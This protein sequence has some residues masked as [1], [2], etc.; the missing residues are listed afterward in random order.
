MSEP[1][2][3]ARQRRRNGR[4][5]QQQVDTAVKTQSTIKALVAKNRDAPPA[6]AGTVSRALRPAF[7][8][9]PEKPS[10]WDIQ[11]SRLLDRMSW[12][13]P[14]RAVDR[15]SALTH[16]T[17]G[18]KSIMA[19]PDRIRKFYESKPAKDVKGRALVTD[20]SH[21]AVVETML[22]QQAPPLIRMSGYAAVPE[23]GSGYGTTMLSAEVPPR[24]TGLSD[25]AGLYAKAVFNP[26][27]EFF[28]PPC[29]PDTPAVATYRYRTV[30]RGSF[31]TATVTGNGFIMVRPLWW[32]NNVSGTDAG[33]Y[34]TDGAFTGTTFARSGVGVT[35]QA[36]STLPYA[37]ASQDGVSGRLVGLG[38]RI[39]STAAPLNVNGTVFAAQVPADQSLTGWTI[40]ALTA[41]AYSKPLTTKMALDGWRYIMWQPMSEENIS[42]MPLPG[43]TL[44]GWTYENMGFWVVGSGSQSFVWEVVEHWE[45]VGRSAATGAAVPALMMSHADPVGLAR[46]LQGVQEM[47]DDLSLEGWLRQATANIVDAVAHSDTVARTVEDLAQP[48]GGIGRAIGTIASALFGFLGL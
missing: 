9:A 36:R 5:V 38:L 30:T 18:P 10:G 43:E 14:S 12:E 22:A 48:A 8:L 41:T 37:L 21:D 17:N 26:F 16:R 1:K 42:F 44:T 29:I 24:G 6:R 4:A 11:T 31:A 34:Y 23:S 20:A 25:C 19:W 45:F 40:A 27:G 33:V 7:V 15:L 35:A 32:A 28:E 47:P 46:V 3:N 13:S 39:R 2:G